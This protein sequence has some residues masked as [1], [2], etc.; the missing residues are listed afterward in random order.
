VRRPYEWRRWLGRS[1]RAGTAMVVGV[2]VAVGSAIGTA[3]AGAGYA[4][5]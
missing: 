3:A 4:N 1:R 2:V 5:P